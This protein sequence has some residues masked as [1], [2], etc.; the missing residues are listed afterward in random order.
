MLILIL[1]LEVNIITVSRISTMEDGNR[2][3]LAQEAFLKQVLDIQDHYVVA[4]RSVYSG[5]EAWVED[6]L[7]LCHKEK[8]NVFIVCTIDRLGRRL[9]TI[10]ELLGERNVAIT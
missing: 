9:E 2:S 1:Y 8:Y 3:P 4:C 7:K 6:M 5:A 10:E